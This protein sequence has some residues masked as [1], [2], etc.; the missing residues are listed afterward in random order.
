MSIDR[1]VQG[2]VRDRKGL[3]ARSVLVEMVPANT[4]LER[5][6]QPILLAESDEEGQYVIDEIP[7]GEY[8]LGINIKSTPTKEHPFGPTYYPDTH[9][10]SQATAIIIG[11]AASV[12]EFDLRAPEKLPLVTIRGTIK[13]ADG[14]PPLIDDHPHVRIK[15][16]GLYGQIEQEDIPIDAQGNFQFVLCEGAT[17]SAFAF[18]G[19]IRNQM[20]SAPVEFVPTRDHDR[21][22]LILDKTPDEFRRL[23]PK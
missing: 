14:K 5:W 1:R 12:Q 15:E 3:P 13:R 20:Y 23:R 18:S 2:T 10:R 19:T 11:S 7:P 9:E 4:Q 17:Y 16:P 21:L 6:K 8:Y 22:E